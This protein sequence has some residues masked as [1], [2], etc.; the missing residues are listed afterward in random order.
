MDKPRF[1]VD[2]ECRNGDEIVI[3]DDENIHLRSVLRL[4]SSDRIEVCFGQGEIC[5]CVIESVDKKSSI[6]KIESTFVASKPKFDITLF[7]AITKSER[8]DWAV[9]KCTELGVTHIV[10]FESKFCTAKDRGNKVERLNRIAVSACKQSGR[11]YLPIISSTISFEELLKHVQ[12]K[13][14][15]LAYENDTTKA[16]SV[17]SALKEQDTALIVGS[18]G[19][20]SE[21]EVKQ[22]VDAGAKCVSLGENILRAETAAVALTSV[23][24]YQLNLW[25]KEKK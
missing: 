25:T 12:G 23:I 13:Q 5:S 17:I 8:M 11:A 3:K 16:K 20:F 10:P 21:D 22:L 19:G 18:E 24:M 1:F 14:T 6:A 2:L 9:Q 4:K 7:M 15:I